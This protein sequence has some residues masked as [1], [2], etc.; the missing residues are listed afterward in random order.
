[1][2]AVL[3]QIANASKQ[4]QGLREALGFGYDCGFASDSERSSGGL[5]VDFGWSFV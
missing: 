3:S 1:M 5:L 2:S 4:Q